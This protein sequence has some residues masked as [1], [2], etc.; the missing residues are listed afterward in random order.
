V[1][2]PLG[3]HAGAHQIV[4]HG[5]RTAATEGK[6]VRLRPELHVWPSI[7]TTSD[8][9]VFE[10]GRSHAE[11]FDIL[12]TNRKTVALEVHI[13]NAY[14]FVA[15]STSAELTAGASRRTVM[16]TVSSAAAAALGRRSRERLRL[17]RR[18]VEPGW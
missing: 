16:A 8:G 18:L 2:Q 15:P 13:P 17:A 4:L 1:D 12:A 9:I 14:D 6:V 7:V 10:C 11:S 5:I 3:W